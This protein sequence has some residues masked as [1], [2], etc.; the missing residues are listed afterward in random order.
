MMRG[1]LYLRIHYNYGII[2][3]AFNKVGRRDV[4][5]GAAATAAFGT[6]LLRPSN[7]NAQD[8]DIKGIEARS[9]NAALVAFGKG[10]FSLD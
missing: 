6:G 8:V 9:S 7:A 4:L 3:E 2:V 10:Q 5:I 1:F